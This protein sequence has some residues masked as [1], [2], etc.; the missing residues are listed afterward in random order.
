MG[1]LH[2]YMDTTL[3]G[4]AGYQVAGHYAHLLATGLAL[5]HPTSLGVRCLW[6]IADGIEPAP[7]PREA[8]GRRATPQNGKVYPGPDVDVDGML[9]GESGGDDFWAC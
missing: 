6:S 5:S 2:A 9:M 8:E 3:P 1:Y 7:Q 4:G